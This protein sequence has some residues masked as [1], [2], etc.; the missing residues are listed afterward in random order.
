MIPL[1]GPT[2]LL[3][4]VKGLLDASSSSH[5]LEWEKRELLDDLLRIVRE[6]EF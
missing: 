4:R 3:V 2:G 1:E 6:N 5:L